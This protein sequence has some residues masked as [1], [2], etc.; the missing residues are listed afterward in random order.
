MRYKFVQIFSGTEKWEFFCT[1][2]LFGTQSQFSEDMKVLCNIHY[3]IVHGKH[4]YYGIVRKQ[5]I[6]ED[7]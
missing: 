1:F 7:E 3:K 2:V 4:L 5:E 6:Q